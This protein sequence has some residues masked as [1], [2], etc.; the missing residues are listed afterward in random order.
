MSCTRVGRRPIMVLSL[1]ISGLVLIATFPIPNDDSLQWIKVAL[2]AVG[3]LAICV[4]YP[5]THL[6]SGRCVFQHFSL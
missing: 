3:K 2:S 1:L 4:T 5:V 6:H